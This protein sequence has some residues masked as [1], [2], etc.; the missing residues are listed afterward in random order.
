MPRGRPKKKPPE[1]E[2]T[3]E[4]PEIELPQTPMKGSTRD[5]K[6]YVVE[7]RK[8]LATNHGIVYSQI[9]D[10]EKLGEAKEL[11]AKHPGSRIWDRKEMKPH[12]HGKDDDDLDQP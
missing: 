3:T 1:T 5:G 9:A 7:K 10:T 8:E 2:I 12:R 4:E 11:V 6:R